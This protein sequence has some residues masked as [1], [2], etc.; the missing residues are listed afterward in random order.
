VGLRR[1]RADHDPGSDFRVRKPARDEPHDLALPP[2]QRLERGRRPRWIGP[3]GE[4]VDQAPRHR[5]R[6]QRVAASDGLDRTEPVV[7][8]GTLEQETG[9]TGP[10]RLV[11]V[12]V[13]VECRQDE[14][15]YSGERGVGA[16]D[17]RRRQTVEHRHADVHQDNVREDAARE[18]DRLS[19]VGSL[20]HHI[21]LLV[22]GDE[23]GEVAPDGRLV[24]RHEHADHSLRRNGSSAAT[25]KPPFEGPAA[26]VAP[27]E[28]RRRRRLGLGGSV[29]RGRRASVPDRPVRR[30]PRHGRG[31]RR[32]PPEAR[33]APRRSLSRSSR[34]R[35]SQARGG[36]RRRRRRRRPPRPPPARL[37]PA[38]RGL[39][40]GRPRRATAGA[41]TAVAPARRSTCTTTSTSAADTTRVA[42]GARL[43]PRRTAA[44]PTASASASGRTSESARTP[45]PRSRCGHERGDDGIREKREPRP[46][47]R[48]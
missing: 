44:E 5:R 2:G 43:R 1:Q 14:H 21:H 15:A 12:L 3:G 28:K 41:R 39:A 26:R 33:R 4:L 13:E 8:P 29:L 11:H 18:V 38:R 20:A 30:R 37:R 36:R 35:P 27:T 40:T 16:D 23:R 24:V 31:E 6:D 47:P 34:A 17:P 9:G 7:R 19:P 10:E 25:R 22:R 42:G 46:T 32:R 48:I 45:T